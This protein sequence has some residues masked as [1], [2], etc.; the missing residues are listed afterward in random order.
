ML[1]FSAVWVAVG[2]IGV[3]VGLRCAMLA[4]SL[5]ITGKK[6]RYCRLLPA[7]LLSIDATDVGVGESA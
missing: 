5:A 6:A 3:C 7:G 2:R 4:F 1:V